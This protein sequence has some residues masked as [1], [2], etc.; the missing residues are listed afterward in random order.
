MCRFLNVTRS[1]VY[2]KAKPNKVDTVAE[3]AV[4]EEFNVNKK[5]YGTRKLKYALKRRKR[6]I[7][8][9]RRKIGKIMSKY[10]LVSKYVKRRKHR[11]NNVNEDK[12]PNIVNRKFNG[13]GELEVVVSDLTYVKV[14]AVWHYIC[15]LVDLMNREIIGFA[16]GRNKDANLVRRAFCRVKADLRKVHIFHT[17]RGNEFKN[18]II[19]EI[20]KA[21][22]I[23]RSLSAKGSPHDNAVSESMYNILK[24]EL[25]F[26]ESFDNIDELELKLFEYVN[27][28]NNKRVH[29]SLGYLTPIE[30]KTKEK[31]LS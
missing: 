27:W 23:E 17:D 4:I 1:L 13:R 25:I 30:Y 20:I 29:E 28:Y 19:D 12:N 24:T 16:A 9:S 7:N 15:L 31:R 26:G 2:Y 21:F 14:G 10:G 22:G 5:V 11:K 18:Q 6:P 3:N 8:I